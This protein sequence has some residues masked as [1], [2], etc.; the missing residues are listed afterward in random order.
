MT[1]FV[2]G[3]DSRI[4][5][6]IHTKMAWTRNTAFSFSLTHSSYVIPVSVYMFYYTQNLRAIQEE[7]LGEILNINPRKART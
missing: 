7:N 3:M 1:K 4:R 5:I 2:R 6:R